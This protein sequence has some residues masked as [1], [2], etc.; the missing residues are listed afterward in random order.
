MKYNETGLVNLFEA[1]MEMAYMDATFFPTVTFKP[2]NKAHNKKQ[3]QKLAKA[4]KLREEAQ[5][6]IN[7]MKAKYGN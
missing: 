7:G 6:Y 4:S 3:M 2:N 5:S 1:V